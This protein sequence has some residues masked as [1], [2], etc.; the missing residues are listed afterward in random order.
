MRRDASDP[1]REET[2]NSL[3]TEKGHRLGNTPAGT[4]PA[5][6]REVTDPAPEG[7]TKAQVTG[8]VNTLVVRR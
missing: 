6:E 8:T 7:A 2:T 5:M 4:V 1:D 3:V